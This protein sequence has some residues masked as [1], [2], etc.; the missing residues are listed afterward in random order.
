MIPED[1]ALP[2]RISPARNDPVALTGT[3]RRVLA[4]HVTHTAGVGDGLTSELGHAAVVTVGNAHVLLTERSVS[5]YDLA[6]YRVA[7]LE[8]SDAH[9]VVVKSPSNFRWTYRDL[10]RD[11]IYVDAP[12]A[13][14]R[15]LD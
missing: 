4:N 14:T 9:I 13:S 7:G 5:G 10:A 3:S 15:R 1:G 8:P 6:L 11:W 12:G 2:V